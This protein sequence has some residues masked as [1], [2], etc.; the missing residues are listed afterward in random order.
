VSSSLRFE[1]ID[2]PDAFE[3]L[4][5]R[6][7]ELVRA[8]PRPSP[9][10]LHGWLAA[11]W[12]VYGDT[13]DMRVEAAFRGD[14]LVAALPLELAARPGGLR[15]ARLMGR[16]HAALGD[17]LLAPGEPDETG[18]RVLE[19]AT[20]GAVDFVDLFG[21]YRGG[22][23]DRVADH[24]RLRFLE[25]VEAPVLQL[26][27][28]W[29]DTLRARTSSKR[30]NLYRRRR[31]QLDEVGRLTVSAAR[32]PAELA[33][34]LEAAFVLHDLRRAGLP[35]GSELTTSRGKEFHRRAFREL[36]EQGA[37][38][39]VLV[40]VGGLPV[41]FHSFFL[42]GDAMVVHSLAFDPGWAKYSPGL[43]ATH[44][45]IRHAA[46]EGARRVEFLGGGERYKLELADRLEPL[47]ECVGMARGVRG[48]VGAALVRRAFD[49]RTRLRRSRTLHAAYVE[50]LAPL[51][52][53]RRPRRAASQKLARP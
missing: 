20:A 8:A 24:D 51:R 38:R 23:L 9:F 28:S 16:G 41:A 53:L 13:A 40:S 35:D 1:T 7:D 45:A 36:G 26:E 48:A 2:Q 37:V 12:A 27:G 6:W 4:S 29:E 52:R 33:E 14:E 42:V 50:G 15:V 43:V 3:R 11:W 18:R 39:I 22:A 30:R 32:T 47:Y 19:R 34:T 10:F 44:E 5:P 21:P 49:A 31:R 25:R 17:L 46:E